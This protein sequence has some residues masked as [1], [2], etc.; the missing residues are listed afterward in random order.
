MKR[1]R[2]KTLLHSA[3]ILSAIAAMQPAKAAE[4]VVLQWQT[5]NLTEKQFEPIWK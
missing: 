4:P 1:Y 5:A 3:A 2:L